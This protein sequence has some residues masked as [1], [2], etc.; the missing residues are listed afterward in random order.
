MA[1]NVP[2]LEMPRISIS[3]VQAKLVPLQKAG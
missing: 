1:G 3:L 2:Y